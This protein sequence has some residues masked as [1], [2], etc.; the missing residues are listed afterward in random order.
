MGNN[1]ANCDVTIIGAGPY[2]LSAAAFMRRAG[3][4]ARV[5]GEPMAFWE[6]RM[7]AGMFLRS[8]W[9]AS[10]IA[11]PDRKVTLDAYRQSMGN[12][13]SAPIPLDRFVDYGRWYQRQLVPDVERTSVTRVDSDG[14]DFRV[15]LVTGD[16]FRSRRV[17][18]AAGIGNFVSRPAE[19]DAIPPA[20]ASHSSEHRDLTRFKGQRVVV[21]GSGQSALESAALLHEGGA[22]VEVIGRR[23]VLNWVGVHYRLHHL[24]AISWLLYSDRDV[25]PAGLSRI[26]SVPHLFRILPR[27]VQNRAAYRAIR[28]AGSGWLRP[29]LSE[30]PVTLGRTVV[31]ALP[32]GSRLQVKLNDG[33]DR[34]VDHALLATGFRVD[35]SR[36]EFLPYE[37]RAR[38]DTVD[39]YPVLKPGME[40]SVPGLHF[41][42]KPA[43]WSFGP[44]VC[45]VSGTEFAA[46]ELVRF[47]AQKNG[48]KHRDE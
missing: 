8:N 25:G 39:G 12:H 37:L 16:S 40:S 13:L 4:E 6:N 28:P 41:L 22:D 43:A 2:G 14:R 19:F 20:L 38:L 11:D 32:K 47:V 48:A 44:L 27:K 31:S 46:K 29:R 18:I 21:I 10:H 15:S 23:T 30:V 24:G 45:F 42:G 7:P 3:V 26:V 36:Y 9:G 34:T 1:V 17:V 35:L 5:F 33:T